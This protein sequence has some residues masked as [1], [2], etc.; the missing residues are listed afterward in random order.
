MKHLSQLL[1]RFKGKKQEVKMW[2][3]R[4]LLDYVGGSEKIMGRLLEKIKSE[5]PAYTQVIINFQ[6]SKDLT[7]LA[8]VCHKM[9][10]NIQMLGN[11]KFYNNIIQMEMDAKAAENLEDIQERTALLIIDLNELLSQLV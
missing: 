3:K 11:R 10:P 8:A 9:K 6:S 4:F 1:K 5:I 2:D 7:R